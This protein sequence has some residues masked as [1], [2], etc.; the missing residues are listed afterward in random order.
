MSSHSQVRRD[1]GQGSPRI[2]KGEEIMT[3][4]DAFSTKW[5]IVTGIA[6]LL[7]LDALLVHDTLTFII[8]MLI[9]ALVA[10][11]A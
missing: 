4:R 7:V 1:R 3:Q 6:G 5:M 8:G 2:K 10:I 9:A 11:F